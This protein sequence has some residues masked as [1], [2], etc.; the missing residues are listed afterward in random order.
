MDDKQDTGPRH[1]LMQ[2]YDP[3]QIGQENAAAADTAGAD[4]NTESGMTR[5][6]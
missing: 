2:T 3:V 5:V 4:S 6:A 1:A